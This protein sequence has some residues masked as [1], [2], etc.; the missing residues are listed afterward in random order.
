MTIIKTRISS[1]L[2][3]LAKLIQTWQTIVVEGIFTI[4]LS[5]KFRSLLD[6]FTI[7]IGNFQFNHSTNCLLIVYPLHNTTPL[8]NRQSKFIK[9]LYLIS[10]THHRFNLPLF[11]HQYWWCGFLAF[12]LLGAT[13]LC[14]FFF[15]FR[16]FLLNSSFKPG[17]RNF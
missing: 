9:E 3:L 1:L 8:A 15:F 5:C 10:I 13:S 11:V 4:L 12:F 14:Q 17:V 2:L 16:T 6:S 7:D